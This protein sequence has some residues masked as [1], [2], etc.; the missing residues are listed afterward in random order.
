MRVHPLWT[1]IPAHLYYL[2]MEVQGLAC[3]GVQLLLQSSKLLLMRP[4]H[5]FPL[6]QK[7]TESFPFPW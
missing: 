2:F 5:V 6:L 7:K 4:H 3:L 1:W